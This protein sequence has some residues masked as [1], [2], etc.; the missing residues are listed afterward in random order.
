MPRR[1]QTAKDKRKVMAIK[2]RAPNNASGNP[3]RGW[4]VYTRDGDFLGF[5]DEGYGGRQALTSLYPNAI[6]LASIPVQPKTYNDAY[7]EHQI[8]GGY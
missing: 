4:L 7:K 1:H 2:M 5:I 8:T 3:R 6:E